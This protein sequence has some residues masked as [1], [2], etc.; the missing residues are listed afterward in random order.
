MNY[1]DILIF[2]CQ[3]ISNLLMYKY[4]ASKNANLPIFLNPKRRHF[5]AA[6]F[7]LWQRANLV[8][9]WSLMLAR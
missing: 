1:S 6:K 9:E 5:F 3:S 4:L 8:V 2:L 7:T